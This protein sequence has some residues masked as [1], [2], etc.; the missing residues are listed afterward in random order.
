MTTPF[1]RKIKSLGRA[2][3]L[4]IKLG[5]IPPQL[6]GK[7]LEDLVIKLKQSENKDSD[8]RNKIVEGHIRLGLT[9]AGRF[10]FKVKFKVEDIVGEMLLCLVESVGRFCSGASY[11][12]EIT[13]FIITHI[14][15]R[16]SKFL[17]EDRIVCMPGRTVRYYAVTGS[18]KLD[19]IPTEIYLAQKGTLAINMDEYEG[20]SDFNGEY[21]MLETLDDHSKSEVLELL[22]KVTTNFI[23]KK[24][25]RLRAE[26]YSYKEIEPL[27]GYSQ[28]SISIM[29]QNIE[30]RFDK[31]YKVSS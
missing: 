12:N 11:N 5:N 8:T 28:S 22:D 27:V 16:L 19:K 15:S 20:P 31:I 18:S 26:G 21:I 1:Q 13:P 14:H 23:E 4:P 7:V 17:E 3:F 2:K 25:I 30:K 6:D 24:I 29:V 9:I 10:A